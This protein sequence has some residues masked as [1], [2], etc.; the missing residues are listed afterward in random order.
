MLR[1][2]VA[3]LI[4]VSLSHIPATAQTVDTNQ[5]TIQPVT[6]LDQS[7]F[8]PP[9]RRQMLG[10]GRLTTNDLIGDGRDRW[11]TGSISTSRVW[12]WGQWEGQA[13]SQFGDL[14]ELR[15]HGE[16]MSP[17]DLRTP[18]PADRPWAGKLSF[19]LHT[20]WTQGG[21][22]FALGGDLV[23]I[24][25]H[26]HLDDF[27]KLLHDVLDAPLPSDAVLSQQIGNKIRPTFVGEVG[28]TYVVADAMRLRP[29]RRSAR[30]R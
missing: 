13:P 25:P 27:Q 1:T 12:S 26:T 20:H 24:G 19:G 8:P 28:K 2:Y 5:T 30:R 21:A 23:L 14:L 15:L 16:I 3:A 9:S 4:A 6:E 18:N 7:V 11:R 22:E 29:L 17:T 10:Y